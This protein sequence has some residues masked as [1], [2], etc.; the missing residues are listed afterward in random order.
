MASGSP[1]RFFWE[2]GGEVIPFLLQTSRK[3]EWLA[4]RTAHSALSGN[5]LPSDEKIYL[6]V[7]GTELEVILMNRP[8]GPRG[9][10]LD[11][12]DG[13][14]SATF[15]EMTGEKKELERR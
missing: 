5:R 1:K 3:C 2:G 8:S 9:R 6:A 15:E 12:G 13:D 14:E 10:C 4:K 11:E 7:G